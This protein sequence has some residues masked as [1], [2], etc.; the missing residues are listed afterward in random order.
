[1]PSGRFLIYTDN[2]NTVDLFSSLSALPSYNVLL[3]EAV[4]LLVDGSH[5]LRVLHVPGIVNSVA[6]ALSRADF[7]RALTL[8]P[9]LTIH[10]FEPYH[11]VKRG[12]VF[13]LQP[14]R[15]QMGAVKK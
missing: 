1:M 4:D 13:Q 14:P 5:D 12:D 9:E 6:D 10:H 7:D 11:R 15:D 8:E 3:R 2:L